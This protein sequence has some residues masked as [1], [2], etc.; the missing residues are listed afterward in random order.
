[1]A[2]GKTEFETLIVTYADGVATIMLNRPDKMNAIN[3]QVHADLRTCLDRIESDPEIRCV[4]LTGTGRAF[5]SGQDL[6][7]ELDPGES[8]VPD[9]APALDRDYNP[10][11]RRLTALPKPVIAAVNGTAAGAGANL[12]LA[13]DIVLAARSAVLIEAFCRIALVPDVGGTWMLPRIVGRQR[14]LAMMLTGDPVDAETAKAW[15]MVWSVHDDAE[16]SGAAMELAKRLAKG[17]TVA[18]GLTKKAVALGADQDLSAHLDTERDLQQQ[19]GQ[20]GDFA[21]GIKAFLEKRPPRFTG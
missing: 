18:L 8:G 14:A 17:P 5:C 13:C 15:G 4:V 10:L 6:T 11:I 12:A 21:E 20:H 19:A 1:M 2:A 16:L 7:E 9:L 3:R